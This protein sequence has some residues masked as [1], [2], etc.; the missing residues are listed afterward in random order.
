MRNLSSSFQLVFSV[1]FL[2]PFILG[3]LRSLNDVTL[4]SVSWVSV[5]AL[6]DAGWVTIKQIILTFGF[7]ILVGFLLFLGLVRIG[8]YSRKLQYLL[9]IPW[10]LPSLYH[11][12]IYYQFFYWMKPGELAVGIIQGLSLSGVVALIFLKTYHYFQGLVINSAIFGVPFHRFWGHFI[13]LFKTD[14]RHIVSLATLIG[15][16]SFSVPL[17]I[18]GVDRVNLEVFLF[19]QMKFAWGDWIIPVT[20]LSQFFLIIIVESILLKNEKSV[21]GA[22]FAVFSVTKSISQ[23]GSIMGLV[24]LVFYVVIYLY[25]C[26]D[27]VYSFV[28]FILKSFDRELVRS[29]IPSLVV[30]MK[31][32]TILFFCFFLGLTIY[33]FTHIV[34]GFWRPIQFVPVSTALT[35]LGLWTLQKYL[36]MNVLLVY[37]YLVLFCP[38]LIRM[39]LG[40]SLNRLHD[41]IMMARILGRGYGMIFWRVV[42]PQ[43]KSILIGLAAVGACWALFDYGIIRFFISQAQGSLAVTVQSWF[44][45]YRYFEAKAL[46]G[47]LFLL[48]IV[49]LGIGYVLSYRNQQF[50]R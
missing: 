13:P 8:Y 36:P 46:M 5:L 3:L 17:A 21:G 20:L 34:A 23:Y 14:V 32:T 7:A 15:L 39:G 47:F 38:I 10:V 16:T 48:S 6:L 2:A 45:S 31:L 29:L 40:N 42:F 19:Q 35:C 25:P 41:Q 18:G 12:S 37:A 24:A 9:M 43:A 28:R 26:L 30:S 49:T 22:Q 11:V 33:S 50:N 44:A 1:I 27:Q 4:T